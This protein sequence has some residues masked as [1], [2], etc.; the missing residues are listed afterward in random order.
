MILTDD[1][2][3]HI[4]IYSTDRLRGTYLPLLNDTLIKHRITTPPRIAAFLAQV[5]HESMSF[6]HT[7]ELAVGSAYENRKDL[8]NLEKEALDAAHSHGTTTGKFYKGRGL[9]QVTGFYNYK[10]YGQ[11]MGI[12]LI[13]HPELLA[14]PKYAT[15]SAGL[16]WDDHDLNSKADVG[17]FGQ[18]T[19]VIN[20]GYNGQKQRMEFYTLAKKVLNVK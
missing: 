20:G 5:I 12:D 17:L 1:Q 4:A 10:R 14:Q 15:E 11:L 19:K 18:I 13:N 3:D 2:L 6:T 7:E 16:F 8:G 9:I